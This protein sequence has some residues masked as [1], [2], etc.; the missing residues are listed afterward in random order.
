MFLRFAP[1]LAA[2]VALAGCNE[3]TTVSLDGGAVD[4]STPVASGRIVIESAT[5]LALAPSEDASFVARWL[6]AEGSPV[7][8]RDVSF[9]LEG[10]P[11]DATLFSL[12]VLA[13]Y[14]RQR[15]AR[16]A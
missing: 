4:A 9:A 10:M 6:D 16:A 1:L 3:P 5:S 11:R 15:A 12:G 13:E 2:W 14:L 7:A 8:G